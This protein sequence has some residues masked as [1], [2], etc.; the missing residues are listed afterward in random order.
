MFSNND[1]K[2]VPTCAD[3]KFANEYIPAFAWRWNNPRCSIH[4]KN[5]DP[6][7]YACR[8]FELIGRQSR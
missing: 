6:D 7:D 5:I 2:Y 8:N 4:H 3:C 1:F